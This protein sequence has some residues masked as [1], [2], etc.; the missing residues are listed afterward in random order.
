MSHL[1]ALEESGSFHGADPSVVVAL[2]LTGH[3]DEPGWSALTAQLRRG[4]ASLPWP[5]HGA[6]EIAGVAL[7][8]LV[9][10]RADVPGGTF[11]DAALAVL[12]RAARAHPDREVRD[13]TDLAASGAPV[14]KLPPAPLTRLQRTLADD[15]PR[16]HA[17]V[18]SLIDVEHAHL[19]AALSAL[20][21]QRAARLVFA[22]PSPEPRPPTPRRVVTRDGWVRAVEALLERVGDAAHLG[23]PARRLIEVAPSHRQVHLGPFARN[24]DLIPVHLREIFGSAA[25]PAGVELRPS[26]IWRYDEAAHP[27]HVLLDHVARRV[28]HALR[29]APDWAALAARLH[30]VH[31]TGRGRSR[32]PL[33]IAPGLGL[34]ASDGAS[35]EA[36]HAA[37]AGRPPTAAPTRPW[38][39]DQCAAWSAAASR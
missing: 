31:V 19:A 16:E 7:R 8:A 9:Y 10:G 25:T 23:G 2:W 17:V 34:G 35:R 6:Q 14:R 33:A 29:G 26:R 22:T 37:R 27:L 5:L 15:H 30:A 21:E 1:L 36:I 38:D 20:A 12:H 24:A 39:A 32:L 18:A 13:A 11:A 28:R 4:V 3:A